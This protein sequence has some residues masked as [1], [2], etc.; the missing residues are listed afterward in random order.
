MKQSISEVAKEAHQIAK[1]HGWWDEDL[2]AKRSFG[3]LLALMHCEL[4]EAYEEY[5]EGRTVT[6]TYHREDGKPEGVPTELA[7]CVI[8]IFDF[9]AANDI[10]IEKV[11]L[12]KMEFNKT[13]PF[14]HGKKI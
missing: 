10:D 4:S 9:C 14:R 1:E 3:D 8:R 6:E 7:D 13:R 12:E 2:M 5:R 11:I